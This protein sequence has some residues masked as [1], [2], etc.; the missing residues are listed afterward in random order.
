[1]PTLVKLKQE[2]EFNRGLGDI[3]DTLKSAALV[4]FRLFQTKDKPN[5][6]FEKEIEGVFHVIAKLLEF[7]HPYFYE[8]KGLSRAIVVVTSDE[9]FLGE[10]NTLLVNAGLDE[11]SSPR[12]EIII[13]GERGAKFLDEMGESFFTFPGIG[14]EIDFKS[15]DNLSGYLLKSYRKKYQL[16][17]VVYPEFVSLTTQRVRIIQLLPYQFSDTKQSTLTRLDEVIIEPTVNSVLESLVRLY[18]GYKFFE[19]FWSSKQSEYAARIMHLESS[20]SELSFLNQKLA[21]N[22]FRQVHAISD[23][24]IREISASRSLLGKNK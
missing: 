11:R 17:S 13:L 23:K 6:A 10:L 15:I 18:L 5:E 12:D 1:M 3:I 7:K 8:R 4:Q 14:D 22:Y 16:I 24:T 19:I 20:T 2:L 9:G 21:F